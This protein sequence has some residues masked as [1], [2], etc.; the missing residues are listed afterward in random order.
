MQ[1][2]VSGSPNFR[3]SVHTLPGLELPDESYPIKS[4]LIDDFA[5]AISVTE[6]A[7]FERETPQELF[8]ST[9]AAVSRNKDREMGRGRSAGKI[10][11]DPFGYIRQQGRLF[12]FAPLGHF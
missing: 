5:E 2:G 11:R 4:P 9:F 3:S 12:V 10:S 8:P 7:L 6:Q 1:A